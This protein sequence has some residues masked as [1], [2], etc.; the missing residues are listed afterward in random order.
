[1]CVNFISLLKSQISVLE[2]LFPPGWFRQPAATSHPAYQKWKLCQE[3][4]T[5]GGKIGIHETDLLPQL[6]RVFLDTSIIVTI[7][8]GDF[9]KYEAGSIRFYGDENVQKKLRT[10]VCYPNKFEDIMVELSYAA[11]NLQR[12]NAVEPLETDGPDFLIKSSLL[13]LPLYVECK[14]LRSGTRNRLQKEVRDANSQL[15]RVGTSSYGIAVFDVSDLIGVLRV[16]ND[17]LPPRLNEI[18]AIIQNSLHAGKNR[19]IGAVLLIW[20]DYMLLG[21]PPDRTMVAFR[22]RGLV[23]PH[24]QPHKQ[25]PPHVPLFEGFTVEFRLHWV[26]T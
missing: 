17:T 14:H 3:L 13:E 16:D 22:R 15:K 23:V 8:K 26:L 6:A 5:R 24:S 10:R 21:Q 7:T 18:T 1:M 4:L 11:W 25:I 20:D 2:H 12:G 9:Q 19:S